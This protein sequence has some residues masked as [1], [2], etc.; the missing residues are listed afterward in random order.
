MATVGA[1][2]AA[3]IAAIGA[4]TASVVATGVGVNEQRR[5]GKKSERKQR[6]ANAVSK[7]QASV[8]ASQNRRRIIAQRRIAEARN[9]SAGVSEGL[10]PTSSPIAGA[11]ASLASSAGTNTANLNRSFAS[12]QQT[13]N[14]QQQAQNALRKGQERADLAQLPSAVLSTAAAG[15]QVFR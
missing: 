9:I 11:N 12:G 2:T 13:F 5:A 10:T 7:A 15:Q 1:L 4:T 3:Q 8:A 6:E 14:L